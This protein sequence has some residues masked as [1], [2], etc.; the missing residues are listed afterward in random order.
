MAPLSILIVGCGI[1]GPTLASFLLLSS[2]SGPEKPKITI[3]ERSAPRPRGQNIDIR[4]AGVTIIRKLGLESAIRAATTGEEGTQFVDADNRVW[5][6][7]EADK[8]GR[9]QTGTSD[10]E[11]L[12]GR[13]SEL[14]YRRCQDVSHLVQKNGGEGVEFIFGDALEE[15]EQDSQKVH[16]RFANS[17]ERRT[18]DLVVGADGLQS[19]TRRLAFGEQSDH[20]R[21]KRLEMY[22]G[23]FSMPKATTDSE[24]RRWFH[25]PG[26]RGIMVRPSDVSDRS[27]VF[28]NIVN[29][30]DERLRE[31]ATSGHRDAEKQKA[32]LREYFYDAGWECRRIVKEM[33]AAD[34]FYY[35]MVAQVKMDTW[36]TG[37]VVLLGDAGARSY[38]ASPISGMGTT[39]ALSGAYN[40]AGALTRH[41]GD[42]TAAFAE[43]EEKMKPVVERAQKLVPGAPHIFAPETAWGIWVM[44]V[45]LV[46]IHYSGLA[47]LMAMRWGPPANAVPVEEYG[48]EQ[49]PDRSG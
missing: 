29:E 38:C 14:L 33:E 1:A 19:R 24:W 16:V 42:H 21:V 6:A 12:R 5:A 45:I 34:D 35:D 47:L 15:L 28:M 4:G 25:A 20:L 49:L 48:F 36:N 7:I 11:I 40:L 43:Y 32:L 39:L 30:K 22:G 18:F 17:G 23:F 3:L 8:S 13:L 26:R 44:H 41:S 9:V 37:R 10:I 27:T 31:V 2:Q 46:I